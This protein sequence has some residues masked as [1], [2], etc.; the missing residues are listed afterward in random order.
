MMMQM[1]HYSTMSLVVADENSSVT[2]VENYLSTVEHANGLAN[3]VTE[4]I[5]KD[6]A[7]VTFGAVDVLAKG[8][9][10]YVN[11][12]G[13]TGRDAGLEWALG[14]MNDGD[15]IS[16]NTTNLVGDGSDGHTKTVVVGT[17]KTKAKLYNKSYSLG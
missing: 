16:E 14:L 3:I 17:W 9:T 4:V 5:V 10:T 6:N 11:R 7:K 13:I 2:Y 15:T 8:I 12:R 1:H